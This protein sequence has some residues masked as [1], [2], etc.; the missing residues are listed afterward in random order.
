MLI[1]SDHLLIISNIILIK[2]IKLGTRFQ[3]NYMS[4]LLV[5]NFMLNEF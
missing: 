3:R 5:L 2:R 1:I 4:K